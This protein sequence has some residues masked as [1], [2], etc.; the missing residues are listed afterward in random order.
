MTIT[1]HEQRAHQHLQESRDPQMTMRFP[2][3]KSARLR[4]DHLANIPRRQRQQSGNEPREVD[5]WITRHRSRQSQSPRLHLLHEDV[6][7]ARLSLLC[8]WP[9]SLDQSRERRARAAINGRSRPQA[10]WRHLERESWER[11]LGR[12]IV[13]WWTRSKRMAWNS[14]NCAKYERTKA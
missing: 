12:E 6:L 10:S 2:S 7:P 4:L 9:R 1:P 11:S 5:S 3:S 8:L 14:Q 13:W